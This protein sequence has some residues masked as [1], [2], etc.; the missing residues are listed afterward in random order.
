LN[1]TEW[2]GVWHSAG[3]DIPLFDELSNY[4]G[5]RKLELLDVWCKNF[6]PAVVGTWHFKRNSTKTLLSD[7][8]TVSDEAFAVTVVE[9]F[10][11]RWRAEGKLLAE[12]KELTDI[13]DLPHPKWTDLMGVVGKQA[14]GGWVKEGLEQFQS[15]L[16]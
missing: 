11:D 10:F 1:S 5:A 2:I 8:L 15:K 3:Q 14:K 6:F 7:F 9:N 12:G 4:R 13:D 16:L